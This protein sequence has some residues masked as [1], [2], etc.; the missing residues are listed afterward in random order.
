M[1]PQRRA[2]P[3]LATT[4]VATLF[5]A[6][7]VPVIASRA[8]ATATPPVAT[9][10]PSPA[11]APAPATASTPL[12]PAALVVNGRGN[13]H[14]RGMSQWGAFGWATKRALSWPDILL[15]YYGG[16][17]RTVAL[18]TEADAKSAPGGLM[19]VRLTAL[20][21]TQTAVLSD[22]SVLS[23]SGVP[24]T[25]GAFVAR[26]V[27]R[28]VFDV[29]AA[30]KP[31]CGASSG[32]PT[33]FT[34]VGNDVKGPVEFTVPKSTDPLATAP[35]E[36]IGV[37]EPPSAEAKSGRV[38]YYRGTVR[39]VSDAT[40]AARTVNAVAVESYVRGVV[41][42]ESS[43]GWGDDAGGAGMNALRAQ[44]VAARSYGLTESRYTYAKTCDSM[45]CQVYG[46][47]S[48][49]SVGSKVYETLEHPFSDTAVAETA[50][51]VVKDTAGRLVRTEYTSSN[52]GRT[53]G[54]TF[55]A[56]ADEGDLLADAAQQVWTRVFSAADVQKR[57]PSIGVFMSAITTHDGLG[58]EWNGYALSVTISG[59]A[60]RVIRSGAQFRR[61]F[62]LYNH[63][64]ETSAIAGADPA[65]APVGR[66][67]LVGD[68][69]SESIATEFAAVVTPAYPTMD[70]QACSG[71]GM[72]GA[73][74]N[75]AQTP[76]SLDL[77]GVGVVNASE[78]P[79]T[80]I[81]ALGYNDDPATF[82]GE[83]QQMLSAL[84][85]KGVQRIVF[86]TLSTRNTT[87]NYARINDLIVAASAV[88]PAITVVDWNTASAETVRWRWFE[89][90]SLCCWVHLSASGQAEFALFLRRQLDALRAQGLLPVTP[91]TVP[92]LLGL[93]LKKGNAGIMVSTVQRRLNSA[94]KLTGRK[95]LAT[96]GAFGAATDRAV[97][98]FQTSAA[99]PVT[100]EIDR[101][102]WDSLGLAG[103]SDL[104]ILRVGT[105][106]PAVA[107][108]QTALGKVLRKEISASGRYDEPLAALVREFQKNVALKPSGRVGPSTWA[109]LMAAAA[110]G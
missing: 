102:T 30:P 31:A 40:G 83:L 71:R 96:D 50:N 42:R 23:W 36:M 94:L 4:V 97:R 100:G 17:G 109:A 5:A 105:R 84:T 43:P 25:F 93:P 32:D 81:I 95:K 48:R 33:G 62:D 3:V 24:G 76:P 16:D 87:R 6:A 80:A 1:S 22:T 66:V 68:S 51:F 44:A 104:T 65:A 7:V 2:V 54:G 82:E 38:R 73:D 85:A 92:V 90:S 61:D 59:T 75:A 52:G 70:F 35:G 67:L 58:G 86:V 103:R 11:P 49:R 74:C 63:W 9:T 55:P 8:D 15:F 39:A 108:V 57:Y 27:A 13:G 28:N 29:W 77:D 99:L 98:T 41:P 47:A 107:T 101:A 45:D 10:V 20:D 46:G 78:A 79:A 18:L 19:T 56:K 106:H 91:A 34:Q 88:N 69:V 64:F 72:A 14:G 21:N 53:A 110:R 89:N 60:G 26:Q 37:C 12:P